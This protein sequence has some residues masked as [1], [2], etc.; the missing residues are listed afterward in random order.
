MRFF[1]V[2]V[3]LTLF[4][5]Y[6]VL[7]IVNHF[8]FLKYQ[9]SITFFI[10]FTLVAFQSIGLLLKEPTYLLKKKFKLERLLLLLYQISYIMLGVTQCLVF[11]ILVADVITVILYVALP[12]SKTVYI[13]FN[14]F[15]LPIIII[16]TLI[17]I[18]I[19][20][21]EVIK[22]PVTQKVEIFIKN[23]PINFE[24]FT[25]VQI[26]DL[27]VG[28]TIKYNYVR[29]VV[30]IANSLKP[31]LITLTGDIIDGK[32]DSLRNDV[33]PLA[34]LSST[35]GKFFVT[36]NHEYYSGA[37]EWIKEFTAL[38]IRN[39]SNEHTLIENNKEQIILAGITDYFTIKQ[40]LKETSS[41]SRAIVGA[42]VGLVKILLAHQP[43]SYV[44]AYKAGFDLQLSGHTHAGQYFPFTLLIRF[45]HRYYKGLNNH[46]GMWIYINRGTGYW[47]PPLRVGAPAEITLITLRIG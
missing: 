5:S 3:V 37:E 29:K 24:R 35:H 46:R 20:I 12:I 36:G 6:I 47:G 15:S 39:L 44:E 43:A 41:P 45:F 16:I 30:N 32:V 18:I 10:I 27:H 2:I 13:Y 4:N 42:P 22:G 33:A 19:G 34:Q 23:L 40:K 9:D 11:Y 17:T 25:I 28:S 38:G 8:S 1:I 26:S 31:N 7:K 14:N 21:I